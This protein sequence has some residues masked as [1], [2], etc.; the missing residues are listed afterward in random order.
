MQFYKTHRMGRLNGSY[1]IP[2]R[3]PGLFFFPL[4]YPELYLTLHNK[5]WSESNVAEVVR[6]KPTP[7]HVPPGSAGAGRAAR[8]SMAWEPR[9]YLG[10]H[11]GEAAARLC[12]MNWEP[13]VPW[14]CAILQQPSSA[15]LMQLSFPAWRVKIKSA[16]IFTR[17]FQAPAPAAS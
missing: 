7:A 17:C 10:Q 15:I 5:R 2:S 11:L 8:S 13:A 14:I 16:Q 1:R 4:K 6:R 9:R 12:R 3:L